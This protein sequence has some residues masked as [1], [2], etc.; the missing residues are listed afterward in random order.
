MLEITSNIDIIEL[1]VFYRF[2]YKDFGL[3][4]HIKIRPQRTNVRLR[5]IL[6]WRLAKIFITKSV[7]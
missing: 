2:S 3:C 6:I 7:N 1:Y 4:S 5:V